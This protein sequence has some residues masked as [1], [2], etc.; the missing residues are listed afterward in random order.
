MNSVAAT[1][2]ELTP[3]WLSEALG[4]A[5]T[6]VSAERIGTGQIGTTYRLQ[7]GYAGEAGPATLVA[8]LAGGD[9][10]ARS[11]V[12]MG[13]AKE[14]GFY[15]RLVDTVEVRTPRCW[16]GAISDDL[17]DF[18][19]LLDDL[20][21]SRPGVQA[22]GCSVAQAEDGVANLAGLHAPRWDDAS[23]LEHDFLTPS[24]P[25]SAAFVG[26]LLVSAT[27]DFVERYAAEL[28]DADVATLGDAA[29]ATEAWQ[30]T[31]P[32]PM[33]LVHG[34]YRLD[35]LMFPIVGEGVRALDWQTVTVGPPLRDVAYF[36]GNSL[37]PGLRG[38]SEEALVA[39]YHA[40][41]RQRGVT[42]YDADT[43]WDDYRL[44]HLQGPLI[45]VLG[46]M[47]ATAERS[48]RSDG[49]FLAMA[50]RSCAAIRE[51]RSLDLV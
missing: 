22:E 43:C 42:G 21:D 5:V 46:C 1:V 47:Y 36:L 48:A 35:N 16:Y 23:L 30:I 38:A 37:E 26:A 28:S 25:E 29:R 50:T 13:Y 49:M 19:L 27:E 6:A 3:E 14:V 4:C 32:R 11:R 9:E 45:T 34:D 51:L 41:I 20:A 17:A 31:R 7:L 44:G 2:D 10:A 18:V 8:K 39:T 15:T 40:A 12:K 24:T 33:A